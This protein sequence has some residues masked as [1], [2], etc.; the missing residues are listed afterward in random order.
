MPDS[1]KKILSLEALAKKARELKSQGKKV[2]LSHGIFDL[3]HNGHISHLKKARCEGDV[4]MVTLT[5]DEYV[6]LGPGHP[7]F[8]EKLRAE[9]LA[10]LGCVDYIAINHSANAANV[11]E[12]IQPYG[13]VKGGEYRSIYDDPSGD[14][15]EEKRALDAYGGLLK[16][17]SDSNF[18]SPHLLNDYLEI[19]S[20]E[21]KQFLRQFRETHSYIDIVSKLQKFKNLKVLVIGDAI[22]DEYHYVAP[23]GQAGKG[24]HLAVK[25]DSVERFAGGS[26]AV[27]NHIAGFAK[28]VTLVAGLGKNDGYVDFVRDGL[29]ERVNPNLILTDQSPTIVKRRYVD[30]DMNKLF[31]VYFYNEDPPSEDFEKQVCPWLEQHVAEYDLVVVPDFGNG[32]L[33]QNM[34]EILCDKARFL[35]VNTQI[36]SGNRG[37][38]VINRYSRADFVSLNEP[39]I[40]LATHNRHDPLEP[41]MEKVAM[42]IQARWVAVTRGTKGAIIFD[43]E[44]GRFTEVPSLSMKVVDRIGAG[45]TFLSLAGLCLADG[46]SAGITSFVGSAAAAL[47][48]GTVCNKEP[49]DSVNMYNYIT[50]LLK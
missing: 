22:V 8:T 30:F 12:A 24:F 49:V 48:V 37:Y 23:L 25:Y 38:H 4:L 16:F 40:R 20:S 9:T 50:S 13:F 2:V 36:N 27:A 35:A 39:E 45:D 18:D 14:I 10:A 46:L 6:N 19:F 32:F 15:A 43:R 33:S 29:H 3:I 21:A 5:G 11:V 41:I 7:M 26:L 28:E 44:N 1:E 42:N 47:S 34:V 31:E 17:T